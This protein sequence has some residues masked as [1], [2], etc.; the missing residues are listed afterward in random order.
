MVGWRIKESNFYDSLGRTSNPSFGFLSLVLSLSIARFLPFFSVQLGGAVI[1]IPLASAVQQGGY[2]QIFISIRFLRHFPIGP[3]FY[4]MVR[5]IANYRFSYS[6]IFALCK[7]GGFLLLRACLHKIISIKMVRLCGAM[8]GFAIL[9]S[10]FYG[11]FYSQD[12][13][14][15]RCD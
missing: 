2:V 1:D 7:W 4:W 9:N 14:T 13:A 15:L 10:P 8:A 6:L 3:V 11:S 12:S 5:K